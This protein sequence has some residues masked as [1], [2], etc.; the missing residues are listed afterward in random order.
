MKATT[1]VTPKISPAELREERDELI[2]L[3]PLFRDA[4]QNF[5]NSLL[6][7]R[8]DDNTEMATK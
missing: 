6:I 3:N 2:N 1:N 7:M 4:D 8:S 5:V